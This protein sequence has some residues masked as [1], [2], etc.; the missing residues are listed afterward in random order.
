MAADAYTETV[1]VARMGCFLRYAAW[2]LIAV[3]IGITIALL[4][5]PALIAGVEAIL[6][7]LLCLLIACKK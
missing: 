1:E 5:A 4:Y 3:S 2:A 6:I 7:I